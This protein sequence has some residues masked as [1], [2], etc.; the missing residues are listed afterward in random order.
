MYDDLYNILKDNTKCTSFSCICNSISNIAQVLS[1]E[2]KDVRNKAYDILQ[3]I[4]ES[5]K[6]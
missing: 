2:D 3:K 6:Y 4:M 5:Q 1:S